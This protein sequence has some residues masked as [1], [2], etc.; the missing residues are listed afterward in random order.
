MSA[1]GAEDVRIP[2]DSKSYPIILSHAKLPDVA[3]AFHLLDPERRMP[4]ISKKPLETLI[5]LLL[6]L[7]RET[8]IITPKRLCGKEPHRASFLKC[9]FISLTVR[10]GP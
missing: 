1:S 3:S 6:N 5:D 9:R 7:G 8:A 10:K 2:L 4:W